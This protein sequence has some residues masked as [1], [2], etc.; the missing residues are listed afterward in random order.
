MGP[1]RL[2][3]KGI[4]SNQQQHKKWQCYYWLINTH[5]NHYLVFHLQI[6]VK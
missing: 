2:L 5:V 1:K 4:K 6:K 3:I